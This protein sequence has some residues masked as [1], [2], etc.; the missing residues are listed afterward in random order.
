MSSHVS[1]EFGPF[2]GQVGN[3]RPI[4][5]RPGAGPRKLFRRSNQSSLNRI[6][7]NIPNN[8]LKLRSVTNQPIITL[9]LPKS[10][11]SEAKDSVAFSSS[12]S[13]E[14]LHRTGNVHEWSHQ[15]MHMVRH[16]DEGVELEA[17]RISIFNSFHHH[18]RNFR[19]FEKQRSCA[20]VI[21]KPIHRQESLARSG[22]RGEAAINGQTP[23]QSPGEKYWLTDGMEVRQATPM[24]GLHADRVHV[25]KK[26]LNF[27]FHVGQVGNLR[28]IDNP[29]AT[30]LGNYLTG[31]FPIGRRFP[32]CPTYCV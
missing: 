8:P 19:H 1:K 10:V 24:D 31:R 12:K 20:S 16:H 18:I 9:A 7:L 13:L 14:R 27:R 22:L 21:K 6:R 29:P 25:P 26:S 30:G 17:S 2:V 28:R 23:M 3:L 32:T 5:N 15:E 11:P 4:G